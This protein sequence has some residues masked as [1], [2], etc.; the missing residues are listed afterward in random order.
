M[1]IETSKYHV[2]KSNEMPIVVVSEPGQGFY[3]FLF[4]IDIYV[5]H[6]RFI[7]CEDWGPTLKALSI[8][9]TDSEQVL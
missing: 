4:E 9:F 5:K 1:G 6:D 8:F 2:K 7:M 3:L